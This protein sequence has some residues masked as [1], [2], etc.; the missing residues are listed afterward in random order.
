M[1]HNINELLDIVYRYYPRGA[2]DTPR[3]DTEEHAR[4]V[5]ARRMAASDERWSAMLRRTSQRFPKTLTDRS[6]HL[7][8]GEIDACY[9]FTLSLSEAAAHPMLWCRI[10]FL[11]PYYIIYSSRLIDT[12]KKIEGFNV[13]VHGVQFYIPRSAIGSGFMADPNDESTMSTISKRED[14]TFDLSPDEQPLAAWIDR[15]IEATFG[16]EPMPPEIGMVLV[17]DVTT[18]ARAVGE[19]RLYD[20]LFSDSHPWIK[21]PRSD[22]TTRVEIDVSRISEPFTKSLTVLAAFYHIGLALAGPEIQGAYFRAKTDGVLRKSELLQALA[23]MRL[24]VESPITLRA[25]A[26]G[27]ELEALISA[28]DGE[29][30]PSEGMVAWASSFLADWADSSVLG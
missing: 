20:C 4:L 12:V 2:G 22:E 8:T 7:P 30:L 11:A 10:S 16:G 14:I 25:M 5:A 19:V 28:W 9:S 15:D 26:A 13:T 6:L 3:K 27:R 29:G 24:S 23:R 17:P 21:P 18:D 1:K